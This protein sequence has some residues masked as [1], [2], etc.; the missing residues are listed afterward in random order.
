MKKQMSMKTVLELQGLFRARAVIQ[1]SVSIIL[2][3][4][5]RQIMALQFCLIVAPGVHLQHRHPRMVMVRSIVLLSIGLTV[6][7]GVCLI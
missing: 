7:M 4:T 5:A 2:V 1:Y 6:C 3:A